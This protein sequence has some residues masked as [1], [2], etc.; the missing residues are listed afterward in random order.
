MT[1][2]VSLVQPTVMFTVPVWKDRLRLRGTGGL[3]F[4]PRTTTMELELIEQHPTYA[5]RAILSKHTTR[6]K[7]IGGLV[8]IGMQIPITPHGGIDTG[9]GYQW[10]PPVQKRESFQARLFVPEFDADGTLEAVHSMVK[11]PLGTFP[12]SELHYRYS[13]SGLVLAIGIEYQW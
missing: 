1:S 5:W 8:E 10:W 12:E 4:T 9:V 7:V 3:I 11:M 2:E 6:E 13:L